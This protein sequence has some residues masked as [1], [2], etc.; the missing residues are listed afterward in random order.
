M[1]INAGTIWEVRTTGSQTNG[2]GFYDLDP[3]TS[4]DY[5][6]Q[7]SAVLSVTDGVT[8]GAGTG[9]SSAT[10]GFTAAM[11][12]N[13]CYLAGGGVAIAWY[14]IT[15]C[16]DGNH[17][18]IDRSA[19]ASRVG[20]TC[21]VGGAF[22]IGGSLDQDFFSGLSKA[23][24]NLIYI[25]SGSYTLAETIS[26]GISYDVIGYDTSR[27][28]EPIGNNRPLLDFG[29][30]YQ[31]RCSSPGMDLYNLR[32][33]GQ[34]TSVLADEA[35]GLM[36]RNLRVENTSATADRDA[37][38][39]QSNVYLLCEFVSANG[40]AA[41]AHGSS[42]PMFVACWMHD[43]KV[44][45]RGNGTTT[46]P[47]YH[48]VHCAVSGCA[49]GLMFTG[50][51]ASFRVYGGV[52]YGNTTGISLAAGAALNTGAVPSAIL[53]TILSG[54]TTGLSLDQVQDRVFLNY[55]CWNNTTDVVNASKG[56][57]DLTADPLL[58]DPA[59]D[60]FRLQSGSPCL[61]A[62]LQLGA[63]VGL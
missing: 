42:V 55:N 54:N 4:V 46:G 41:Y 47:S 21:V 5:S 9:L 17:V 16:I 19:G 44:G 18:T 30:G 57:S 14:Q 11:V 28:D 63:L 34:A 39:S 27:G 32:I 25:Q 45:F 35:G 8:D 22:K 50:Q 10:G 1:A 40:Y 26:T 20:V 6:Q 13:T 58:V 48:L 15:A 49:T 3:G 29:T 51:Y 53:N 24:G 61:N 52:L 2:G 56:P 37:L 60:D 59:N 33:T 62:G 36:R 7:D 12:G 31:L 43:S 38:W 23:V